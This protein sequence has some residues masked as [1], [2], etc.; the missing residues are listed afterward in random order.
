MDTKKTVAWIKTALIS[1]VVGGIMAAIAAACDPSKYRFP[2]DLGSGK[3]WP[4]FL[5]GAG[6]MFGGMLLKSP[7]GQSALS[8]FK[9]SQAQLAQSKQDL[10]DAKEQL[11]QTP[12]GPPPNGPGKA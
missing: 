10:A 1:S 7:L 8:T 2:Q 11:K 5:A 4:F 9:D 3:L 6:A 12:T